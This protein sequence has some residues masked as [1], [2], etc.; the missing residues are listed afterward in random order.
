MHEQSGIKSMINSNLELQVLIDSVARGYMWNTYIMY[1]VI[2]VYV[3]YGYTDYMFKGYVM[4][5]NELNDEI[6]D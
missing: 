2:W 1:K 4:S 3:I 6:E 5:L